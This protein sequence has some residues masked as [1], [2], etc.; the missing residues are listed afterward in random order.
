MILLVVHF[1]F[2]ES[3]CGKYWTIFG[4]TIMSSVVIHTNYIF[5]FT[6]LQKMRNLH[7][8]DEFL[9]KKTLHCLF[10][11]KSCALWTWKSFPL[12]FA[13][14]FYL[15][16]RCHSTILL[17]IVLSFANTSNLLRLL[18][19]HP[20]IM[21]SVP[22]SATFYVIRTFL[23]RFANIFILQ[24]H[25]DSLLITLLERFLL[26]KPSLRLTE[27]WMHSKVFKLDSRV[28]F[29]QGN[30][31]SYRPWNN[32]FFFSSCSKA[33]LFYNERPHTLIL[34][35]HNF[36]LNQNFIF[37]PSPS[38]SDAICLVATFCAT[39]CSGRV[40]YNVRASVV[41]DSPGFISFSFFNS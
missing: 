19:I 2:K 36:F 28:V 9:W 4:Q 23:I 40:P 35:A 30:P 31:G 15:S 34:P 1:G 5:R 7:S 13:A 20:K 14:K 11:T 24:V 8:C 38:W 6:F 27:L 12:S 32:L 39:S 21:L 33:F 26:L 37:S 29:A 17:C 16:W 10:S 3:K 22:F 41:F 18:M 25:I